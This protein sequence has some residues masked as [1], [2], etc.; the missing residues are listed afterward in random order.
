MRQCYI[1]QL[2]YIFGIVLRLG[3]TVSSVSGDSGGMN[4][5]VNKGVSLLALCTGQWLD[6]PLHLL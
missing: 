5:S 1:G 4:C 2:C 6:F 3:C